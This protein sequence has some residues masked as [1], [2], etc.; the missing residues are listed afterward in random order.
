MERVGSKA[1]HNHAAAMLA[2]V[3]TESGA[4]PE[5]KDAAEFTPH[6]FRHFLVTVA[7]Q[8]RMTPTEVATIGHWSEGST[9]PAR[10]DSF[11]C[12]NEAA[13]KSSVVDAL[14]A[15]YRMVGPFEVPKG[16]P[17]PARATGQSA[18]EGTW[19][20]HTQSTPSMELDGGYLRVMNKDSGVVHLWTRSQVSALCVPCLSLVWPRHPRRKRVS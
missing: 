19:R 15:G 11:E 3:L 1:A 10:Y 20:V 16:V 12:V 14:A 6:S 13:V 5:I 4:C 8:L 7:R 18:G 17:Q 2:V 9:M